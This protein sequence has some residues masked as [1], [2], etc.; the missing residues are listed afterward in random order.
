MDKRL[1]ACA[2]LVDGPAAADIGTDHGYLACYLIES[3]RCERVVASDV[4]EKP[5]ESARQNVEAAGLTD[6]VSCVL[7]DGLEK[8]PLEGI[9]DIICAG[10]GGELIVSILER[11]NDL[12]DKN[13]VLQP[14]TKWDVLRKWLYDN[15]FRVVKETACSEGRFVYS[16]MKA[17]FS[18]TEPEYS[19]DL[20]YLYCGRVGLE[21]PEERAYLLR[22]AL[23]LRTAGEGK[24][25]SPESF[26]EGE[27][28][29][30]L[31]E[32]IEEE[33]RKHGK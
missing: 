33:V 26:E 16:V 19:C 30:A 31:A 21:T 15:R 23:R 6:R 28:M 12:R 5:L 1:L 14:M 8:V 32:E 29:C 2:G 17:R 22:Q 27:R 25:H 3:G 20:R 9:T 10:M 11:C 7:S 4:A 13:L 24:K 18:G